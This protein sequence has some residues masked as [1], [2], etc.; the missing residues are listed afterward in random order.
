MRCVIIERMPF[1]TVEWVHRSKES[2]WCI[3]PFDVLI[4]GLLVIVY[5][6]QEDAFVSL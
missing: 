5:V 1:V 2:D 6:V 3:N 4:I